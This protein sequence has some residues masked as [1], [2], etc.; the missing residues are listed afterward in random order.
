[1][2]CVKESATYAMANEVDCIEWHREKGVLNVVGIMRV[3]G[4]GGSW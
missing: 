4:E 1:M 2:G 3:G